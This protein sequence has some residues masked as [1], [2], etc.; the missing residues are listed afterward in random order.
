[1]PPPMDDGA[2]V[3]GG[4]TKSGGSRV[5]SGGS[6]ERQWQRPPTAALYVGGCLTESRGPYRSLGRELQSVEAAPMDDGDARGWGLGGV[7]RTLSSP[8]GGGSESR[9]AR[10]GPRAGVE[11]EYERLS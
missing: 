8:R 2:P 11:G 9:G 10:G 3:G 5:A 1:V 6:F 4:S 7:R